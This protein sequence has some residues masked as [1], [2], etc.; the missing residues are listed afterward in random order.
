LQTKSYGW[1][2]NVASVDEIQNYSIKVPKN[3]NE[4]YTSLRI[5]KAIVEFLEYYQ[6]QEAKQIALLDLVMSKLLEIERIVLPL[7][8]LKDEIMQ[9]K[10]DKF[11]QKNSIDLKLN[12]IDFETKR[13]LSDKKDELVCKKRMGFTPERKSSGD[14]PWITVGDLTKVSGLFIND[15]FSTKEKT[16]IDLIEEKV[17]KK[18]SKFAPIKKDDVLVSFK[19]TVG[20]VKIYN[21]EIPAYCNEAIDILS[22]N[23]DVLPTYLAYQCIMEYPKYGSRTNNGITLNDEDK[24]NISIKVPHGTEVFTSKEIQQFVL[25]FLN[26]YLEKINGMNNL[27]NNLGDLIKSYTQTL[28]YKI[29]NEST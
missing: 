19:L 5:Q 23:S 4:K 9:K 15:G 13:I 24:K 18:S 16:T 28:I 1:G 17:S 8:F 6:K 11:C 3:L 20:E 22:V 21:C 7:F 2:R 29:F 12:K 26:D 25:N 27:G 10:F 14:I